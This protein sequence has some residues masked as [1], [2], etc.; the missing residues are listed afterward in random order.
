L[1]AMVQM[2]RTRTVERTWLGDG[3]RRHHLLAVETVPPVLRKHHH[4]YLELKQEEANLV[5]Q[6]WAEV[7]LVVSIAIPSRRSM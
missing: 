1:A 4:R 7:E 2:F 3:R 5:L 6:M